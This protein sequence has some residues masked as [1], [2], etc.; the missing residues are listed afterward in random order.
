MSK[1]KECFFVWTNVSQVSPG[2]VHL[3]PRNMASKHFFSAAMSMFHIVCHLQETWSGNS[4]SAT[5]PTS[6]SCA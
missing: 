5:M 3:R 1:S 2:F 4:V 6:L